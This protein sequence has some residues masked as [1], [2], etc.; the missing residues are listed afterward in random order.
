MLT[1]LPPLLLRPHYVP[2]PWG[3]RRLET[4]FARSD[5]PPGPIGE[6]WEAFDLGGHL[7]VEDGVARCSLIDGGPHDGRP[8]REVLGAPLPLLLKVLDAHVHL[9]IQVHPDEGSG[10]APKEEAWVALRT[11]GEVGVA[12]PDLVW[13]V[14]GGTP[15]A[16]GTW[17]DLLD[18]VPLEAGGAR[19][20]TVVHVPPGTVH[21]VLAGA[22]VFEVQNPVDVT[23]RLDD[24]GRRDAAG[25]GRT[26]HRQEAADLLTRPTPAPVVLDVHGRL[27]A[28]RFSLALLAS[29]EHPPAGAQAVFFTAAGVVHDE[30]GTSFAVPAGRTV[31]VPPSTERL[32]SAGLMIAVAAR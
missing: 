4:D 24:H 10:A 17:L 32:A 21:A 23:W 26:L 18:R 27:E 6:S 19:L 20:P 13:R 15:P 16:D 7:D 1:G 12:P 25:R 14:P 5:L 8:L 29:G 9:S 3:G 28:A 22:F 30:A 31:L 2:K 11:G